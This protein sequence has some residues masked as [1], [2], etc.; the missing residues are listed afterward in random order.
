MICCV[1]AALLVGGSAR[2][3]RPVPVLHDAGTLALG[4]GLGGLLVEGLASFCSDLHWLHHGRH[5]L[6]VVAIVGGW[7]ALSV[8]GLCLGERIWNARSESLLVM[9]ACG[10]AMVTELFD[11]HVARLHVAAAAPATIL[12]HAPSVVLGVATAGLMILGKGLGHVGHDAHGNHCASQSRTSASAEESTRAARALADPL[13]AMASADPDR[14]RR[15]ERVAS[16]LTTGGGEQPLPR[17][18]LD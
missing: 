8:A 15:R 5:P 12:V 2:F 1:L 14:E 3:R 9:A 11:L 6:G 13:V 16:L 18:Q 7:A 17:T 10:G 4:A